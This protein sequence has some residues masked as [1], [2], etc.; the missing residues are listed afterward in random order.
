MNPQNIFVPDFVFILPN[1]GL[2]S[3]VVKKGKIKVEMQ[4]DINGK[5]LEITGLQ[6]EGVPKEEAQE[7]QKCGFMFVC[8]GIEE[9]EIQKGQEIELF[10]PRE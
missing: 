10:E 5:V 8:K 2:L 4:A 3:G 7:G 6:I 1:G 9:T